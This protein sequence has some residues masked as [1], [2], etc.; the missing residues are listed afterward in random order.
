MVVKFHFMCTLKPHDE[1]ACC[2]LAADCDA[3]R[4]LAEL[5][6]KAAVADLLEEKLN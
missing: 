6:H 4:V 1:K 5:L 3:H 2:W